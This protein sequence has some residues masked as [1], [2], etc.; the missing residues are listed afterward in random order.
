MAREITYNNFETSLV[1]LI[2]AKYHSDQTSL[3]EDQYKH[4]QSVGCV[5]ADFYGEYQSDEEA[6]HNKTCCALPLH[7]VLNDISWFCCFVMTH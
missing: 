1:V 3:M 2:Y 4:P 5:S 6:K 7:L